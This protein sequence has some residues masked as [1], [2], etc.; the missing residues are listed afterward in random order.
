MLK[1][2]RGFNAAYN[3]RKEKTGI[4]FGIF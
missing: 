2:L 4:W 1:S 3:A